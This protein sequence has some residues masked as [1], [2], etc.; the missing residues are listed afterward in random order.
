MGVLLAIAERYEWKY[1]MTSQ[2]LF[3]GYALIV[4]ECFKSQ[5]GVTEQLR[6]G[7]H[8]KVYVCEST[9]FFYFCVWKV[10]HESIFQIR[11][12]SPG[13]FHYEQ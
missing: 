9:Y 10:V 4:P 3:E 1:V 7:L 13:L 8:S 5:Q 12:Y 2:S 11:L 6:K